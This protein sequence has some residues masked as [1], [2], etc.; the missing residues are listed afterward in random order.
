MV[1]ILLPAPTVSVLSERNL[2]FIQNCIAESEASTDCVALDLPTRLLDLAELQ[3]GRVK[4]VIS[5]EIPGGPG[6]DVR[7]G[8]LSYCWGGAE[9]LK[10]TKGNMKSLKQGF[11]L[12]QLPTTIRDAIHITHKLGLRYLCVDALC[13]IQPDGED[14]YKADWEEQSAQMCSI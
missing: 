12:T 1:P 10:A 4:L 13:I 14:E 6:E 8:A 7:Y 3:I 11:S 9:F 2:S 5:R